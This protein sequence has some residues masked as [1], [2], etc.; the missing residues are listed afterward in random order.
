MNKY[1]SIITDDKFSLLTLRVTEYPKCLSHWETLI[2]HLITKSKPI[3]KAL[4]PEL[5][6]LIR[7]TYESILFHFPYLENY[8]IDYALFEFKLGNISKVHKTFKQALSIFNQRSLLLWISYLKI[9]NDIILEPKQL[10]KKYETAE[11]Y[12]GLHFYSAEFWDLY[13]KQLEE[14]C[15][16]KNRYFI[17][18]RKIL[19]IPLY[20][21]SKFYAIW[22]HHIDNIKDLS[23]LTYLV[24]KDELLKKFNIDVDFRRRRGL[25]LLDAKTKL[26]KL[27]KE[28]YTVTQCQV[29]EMF[30]LFESKITT[31]YYTS[32]EN[33]IASDEIVI[34]E[35]YINY[36]INLNI[37]NLIYLN[38]QRALLPLAHYDL[39]WIKY[40]NWLIDKENDLPSANNILLQGLKVSLKKSNILKL[41]YTVLLRMN[42]IQKLSD[43]L[44][45]LEKSY[46]NKIENTEDFSLFWDFIQFT[47]FLKNT[48]S[49]SRYS[50]AT[51]STELLPSSI[52]EKIMKRLSYGDSKNGQEDIL[53]NLIQLQTKDNT[54]TIEEEV[55]KRIIASKWD[56]YLNNG[57]FWALYSRLIFFDPSRS[58]L[59]KRKYIVSSIWKVA[60]DYNLK[61]KISLKEF[62]INYL[63]DD[64]EIFEDLF[65]I[66]E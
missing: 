40:A 39:I 28:L 59:E 36:T 50:D 9:C 41:L 64:I 45:E 16:M 52:F 25:L 54:N 10:F 49:Q 32:P 66:H 23:Q 26:K 48:P 35:K 11:K 63:T 17:V 56:Y 7:N 29:L 38:F 62:C 37:T 18:L 5:C 61:N 31:Q 4:E 34:W 12:I 51:Q 30:T 13:L 21:Y 55:F 3:N 46:G 33:L 1:T 43:I 53:S 44:N 15:I 20:S 6:D 60:S 42:E 27:T 19:E 58:Y 14:R 22:L 24:R 47:I 8:H 57:I 2:S 65:D